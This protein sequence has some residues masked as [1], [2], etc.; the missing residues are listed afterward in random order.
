MEHSMSQTR[1]SETASDG[2]LIHRIAD[3]L[4]VAVDA[5]YLLSVEHVFHSSADGTRW[6]LTSGTPGSPLVRRIPSEVNSQDKDGESIPAFLIRDYDSPQG[7]AL[8]ALID[9]VLAMHLHLDMRG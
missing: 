8:A 6:L 9:R 1:S 3:A 7:K 2:E 5:F 4:G